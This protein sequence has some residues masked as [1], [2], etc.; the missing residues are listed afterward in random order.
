MNEVFNST[1]CNISKR[2]LECEGRNEPL[3]VEMDGDV[4]ISGV[5]YLDKGKVIV[6]TLLEYQNGYKLLKNEEG[7][8][9]TVKINSY[10]NGDIIY[11][12]VVKGKGCSK[13]EYESS[14]DSS[15]GDYLNSSTGY[16]GIKG[17]ND[18]SNK[19]SCLKFYAFSDDGINKVSLLL[20][21][22]TT[23]IVAW[24][25]GIYYS[26]VENWGNKLYNRKG[27]LKV[28]ELLYNDTKNWNGTMP[29]KN[30]TLDQSS[31]I[32]GANYTIEYSKIPSYEGA[33]TPYKARLITAQEIA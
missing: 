3:E 1:F 26:D 11:F 5:I 27:P 18:T 4:P 19:N 9:K 12:D 29:L 25:N 13:S 7:N 24:V 2:E 28:L 6:N 17:E 16:N 21:H 22:N 33:T 8:L 10:D 20:D 15:I 31:Q 30:Y 14:F 23:P 32:S